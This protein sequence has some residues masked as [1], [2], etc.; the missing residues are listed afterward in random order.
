MKSKI[1]VIV[2]SHLTIERNSDFIKHV[3]NTIG[4]NHEIKIIEN[5]NKFSLA[6]I[7]NKAIND[8]QSDDSIMV[9]CHPDIIF[10]TNYWGRLLL[11][12]FNNSNYGII[13]VAGTTNLGTTAKWWSDKQFMIGTVNHTDGLKEWSNQYSESFNGIKSVVTIDGL[14]IAIDSQKIVNNFDINYGKFH[15]YD[16]SFC[17][18]NYLNGVDVGVINNIRILHKS[19]GKTNNEWEKN[20]IKFSEQYKNELPITIEPEYNEINVELITEPKVSVIIPT[21][22]N[23][24]IL[25]QNIDSWNEIV[26]YKNYEI[27]IADTG[28]DEVTLEKYNE[29]L[30]DKIKL[31]KYDYYNFAKINNDV[32]KNH[33][34]SDTEILLFCNDDIELLNDA[35]SRCVELYNKNKNIGTI[36]IRL[37]YKNGSIQHCGIKVKKVKDGLN[38]THV[39]QRKVINYSTNVKNS[40]GNTG[41][42][43]MLNKKLFI[44]CEYFNETYI[45]CLEDVELNFKLLLK[46]KKNITACDAVAYHYESMS[47][48]K[49]QGQK[50]RIDSDYFKILEPFYKA[51]KSKL[52][53]YFKINK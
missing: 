31:I 43:L 44:E 9:F 39:D 12:H 41:A 22:N 32:V 40:I 42:F 17:V 26:K 27:I 5:F 46:N 4:V 36:G 50:E 53:K 7:Y 45:E 25:K 29:F 2:S 18:P 28:S 6:E 35:L 20:R 34:S 16:I 13:G 47:R 19:I 11:T 8:Y 52:D 24:L 33:I 14:F 23:F 38:L 1:I 10:K 30:S 3:A 21:K 37:H 51:N 48:N 15:F 49:N